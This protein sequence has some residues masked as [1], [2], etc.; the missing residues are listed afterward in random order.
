M[1]VRNKKSKTLIT[2]T[3]LVVVSLVV[4]QRIYTVASSKSSP[5][6]RLRAT[7]ETTAEDA[8]TTLSES[9]EAVTLE[10]L[11]DLQELQQE[12]LPAGRVDSTPK[13]FG[14]SAEEVQQ[15][16]GSSEQQGLRQ[17]ADP[18]TASLDGQ[19]ET[20]AE[21]VPLAEQQQSQQ[22]G[23]GVEE[24]QLTDTAA[25]Q[26]Q[27]T[28]GKLG[29]QPQRH[30]GLEGNPS[31]SQLQQSPNDSTSS[32]SKQGTEESA[33]QPRLLLRYSAC[34][35][36]INQYYSHLSA[37][38][39][40][41][42]LGADLV[43]ARGLCR[44]SFNHHFSMKREE[45]E[46]LW[47]AAPPGLL[48]DV[49][50]IT[51]AWAAQ[52]MRVLQP[53]AGAPLPDMAVPAVAFPAYTQPGS[54]PR[55]VARLEGLY[56]KPRELPELAEQAKQAAASAV[57]AAKRQDPALQ[58]SLVLLDLPCTMFAVRTNSSLPL[59]GRVAQSLPFSPAVQ[60]LADRIVQ[61]L[62]Q[63]GA[64]PFNGAHLRLETDAHDWQRIMRGPGIYW[65]LHIE[66]MQEAAFSN[67]TQLYVACGLL[68][69]GA[70]VDWNRTTHSILSK[71]L[72]S[73]VR[74]KEDFLS[75]EELGALNSEQ[76]AL[77]DLLVLARAQRFVGFGASSFSFFLREYRALKYGLPKA[78][79]VLVDASRVGTD[80]MF[81]QAA[82]LAP[83]DS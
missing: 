7:L 70:V 49:D 40:A 77:L 36:L 1:K 50:G 21:E 71:G 28:T 47:S 11:T 62:T 69:Y 68:S 48:L 9:G 58:P 45:N 66:A 8:S 55:L 13:G 79:T 3:T 20:A 29:T 82:V 83:P 72:A 39:L 56:L 80:A 51:A 22:Q 43:L 31:D 81:A 27:P 35:G 18:L 57:E 16:G 6:V 53:P 73:A 32:G 75:Q 54:D 52:G 67:S 14:S 37:F 44:D 38:S 4:S 33:Q 74:S 60:S 2:V 61:Q 78:S 15:L 17:E 34:T 63:G 5:R 30:S 41:A 46:V 64:L 24:Q 76:K 23:Q 10:E 19:T 25:E 42:V 65:R 59:V 12:V 26:Q